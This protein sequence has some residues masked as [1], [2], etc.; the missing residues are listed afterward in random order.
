MGKRQDDVG[1]ISDRRLSSRDD[2]GKDGKQK[3][4]RRKEERYKEDRYKEKHREDVDRDS[5]H[6]D[7][8]QREERSTKDH[9]GSKSED[10]HVRDE[11][12]TAEMQSKTSKLH[13]G[14]RK[15]ENDR[16]RDRDRHRDL[17]PIRDRDR[18]RHH[19]R[20]RE[21]ERERARDRDYDRDHE[22]DWDGDR[23]RDRD[24]E[25]NRERERERDRDRDRD[26][27]RGH[28]FDRDYG[29][30][31]LDDRT[32][33]YKDS[34]RAKRRSPDDRDDL[35]D[36]P[37]RGSKARYS[38]VEKKSVSGDRTESDANK[39]RS[40]SRQTH[41]D[42]IASND[43]QRNSPSSSPHVGLDESRY[44]ILFS[45][46]ILMKLKTYWTRH[47]SSSVIFRLFNDVNANHKPVLLECNY[48]KRDLA[49][50]HLY[51]SYV[52]CVTILMIS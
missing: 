10:K 4:E 43:K 7:D 51:F 42:M 27:D 16:D 52:G 39:R 2:I 26:Y 34:S 50:Y 44:F 6:R 23:D 28:D 35:T 36:I 41:V 48:W 22:W 29:S 33:R 21:H 19:D 46:H 14:E 8:R 9:L 18:D 24:R 12:D 32:T 40:H 49:I 47:D 1:D 11:K 30:S 3:D 5:K 13:D 20:E 37:S 31:H 45:F 15:G 38:D 17:N 25:R